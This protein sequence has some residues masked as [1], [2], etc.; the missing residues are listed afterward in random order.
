MNQEHKSIYS[1]MWVEFL[2]RDSQR[3]THQ[4]NT[5][6]QDLKSQEA[7]EGLQCRL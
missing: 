2:P 1:D 3:N 4:L 5:Y 6:V 7:L